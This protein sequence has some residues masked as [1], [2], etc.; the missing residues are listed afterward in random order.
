MH[1]LAPPSSSLGAPT[2]TQML[3]S[4]SGLYLEK[5]QFEKLPEE[6][7]WVEKVRAEVCLGN[8]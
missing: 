1:C 5:E 7:R 8:M 2:T 4:D 3:I 6:A